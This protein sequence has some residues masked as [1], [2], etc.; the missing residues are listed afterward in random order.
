MYS[1]LRTKLLI[2]FVMENQ[3]VAS[4]SIVSHDRISDSLDYHL[5]V[6]IQELTC[7]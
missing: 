6:D 7:F 1:H 4:L 3:V 5:S 2:V